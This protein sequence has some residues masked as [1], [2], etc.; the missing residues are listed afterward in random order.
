[1]FLGSRAQPVRMVDNLPRS[2]CRF[3]RQCGILNILQTYRPPRSMMGI[4]SLY[5]CLLDTVQR[6]VS[7]RSLTGNPK[8]SVLYE[9]PEQWFL[10]DGA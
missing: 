4:A 7:G 2:V 10:S 6:M 9:N 1:M 3:S 5:Y 8:G